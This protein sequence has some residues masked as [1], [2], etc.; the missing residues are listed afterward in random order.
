MKNELTMDDLLGM[1]RDLQHELAEIRVE[2]DDFVDHV[3]E[4][5]TGTGNFIMLTIDPSVEEPEDS[6]PEEA[7]R[8]TD[9]G[10]QYSSEFK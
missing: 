1:I 8:D 3:A 10:Q 2:Q 6:E 9:N 7:E 5:L 4:L